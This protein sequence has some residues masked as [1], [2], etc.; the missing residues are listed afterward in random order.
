MENMDSKVEGLSK[1]NP[2]HRIL[3]LPH[4]LRQANTC[5]A[6][7]NGEGLQCAGCNPECTINR[8]R[9]AAVSHGYQGVCVAPGGRLAVNFVVEKHPRAVVA[10]ACRK[11]IKERLRE[12]KKLSAQDVKPLVVIIP[13][14]KDGCVDTVVDTEAALEIIASGCNEK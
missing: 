12:A 13:L 2:S 8:L 3:L 1:I 7:Y 4:C 11:E 10:I 6:R 5:I 9:T 14:L